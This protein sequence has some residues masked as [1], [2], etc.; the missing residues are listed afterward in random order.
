MQQVQKLSVS[1]LH[2]IAAYA[3][4]PAQANSGRQCIAH[5]AWLCL[6]LASL[7]WHIAS[8]DF[9][10]T[11]LVAKL[12]IWHCFRF[13]SLLLA[14][15]FILTHIVD[16]NTQGSFGDTEDCRLGKAAAQLILYS[17]MYMTCCRAHVATDVVW[18]VLFTVAYMV[19]HHVFGCFP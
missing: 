17:L 6:R 1:L 4:D 12:R 14:A 13:V 9:S 19:C 18:L 7:F 5:D 11:L 10:N 2:V 16:G 3:Q 8:S 15:S